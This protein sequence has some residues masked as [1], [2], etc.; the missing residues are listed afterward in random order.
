MGTNQ[1]YEI[2]ERWTKNE[3]GSYDLASRMG[4]QVLGQIK[5]VRN[6]NGRLLGPNGEVVY[7][8]SDLQRPGWMQRNPELAKALFG[9]VAWWVTST[10]WDKQLDAEPKPCP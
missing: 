2:T 10:P 9:G 7:R 1:D 3:D 8:P 5:S 4:Q 6:V